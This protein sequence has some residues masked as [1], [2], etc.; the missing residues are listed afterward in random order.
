MTRSAV[1]FVLWLMAAFFAA[2]LALAPISAS[3]HPG[4]QDQAMLHAPHQKNDV[5]S[6][7]FAR[8]RPAPLVSTSGKAALTALTECKA[9]CDSSA[10]HSSCDGTC[11][12]SG[13][14]CGSVAC[15]FVEGSILP[16]APTE[17]EI[18]TSASEL[19]S[20]IAPA[21]LLEPPN[22]FA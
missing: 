2:M 15:L 21:S 18:L 13:M 7:T 16:R 5:A 4:H 12:C 3:A 6:L 14:G 8:G 19:R 20:G 17:S 1:R 22:A 10:A 9:A 11:C